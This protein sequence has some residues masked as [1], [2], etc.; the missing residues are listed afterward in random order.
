MA[1]GIHKKITIALRRV[2]FDMRGHA[3]GMYGRGLASE[4]YLGGY[5]Q[6]L[7]DVSALLRGI[8]PGDPRRFFDPDPSHK[9]EIAAAPKLAG[10][11]E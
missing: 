11:S 1:K 4:G 6:A 8:R 5:Q 2:E 7:R 9:D 3:G 10:G